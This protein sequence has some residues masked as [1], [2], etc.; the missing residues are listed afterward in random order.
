M[1]AL[2]S[3]IIGTKEYIKIANLPDDIDITKLQRQTLVLGTNV[4]IVIAIG[5][6]D[7]YSDNN[8]AH[9]RIIYNQETINIDDITGL[10]FTS[11]SPTKKNKLAKD[12]ED[13]I[14]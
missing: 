6:A 12:K 9:Y 7:S 3:N 5:L 8:H 14:K 1:R 2:F 4:Q 13:R 11:I 10:K